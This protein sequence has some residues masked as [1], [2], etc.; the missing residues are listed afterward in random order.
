[1]FLMIPMTSEN[2]HA[3]VRKEYVSVSKFLKSNR[4]K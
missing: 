1:M 2:F 4:I 3:N